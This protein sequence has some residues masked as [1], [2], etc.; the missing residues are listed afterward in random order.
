M[1]VA[2]LI[3]LVHHATMVTLKGKSYAPRTRQRPRLR[4]TTRAAQKLTLRR[5][6]PA[7]LS[8]RLQLAS[9]NAAAIQP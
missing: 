9:R 3:D 4:S 8:A 5:N 7:F 1:V 6:A 2:A